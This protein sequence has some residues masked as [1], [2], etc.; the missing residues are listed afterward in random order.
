MCVCVI[1]G[2]IK[3][4]A[5]P[6]PLLTSIPQNVAGSRW[7]DR[8]S[9]SQVLTGKSKA[10]KAAKKAK[11]VAKNVKKAQKKAKVAVKKAH[12][13]KSKKAKAAAKRSGA[14]HVARA[15]FSPCSS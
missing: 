1:S 8:R 10:K 11:T 6:M 13:S 12:K 7:L 4:S 3:L 14:D 15:C 5:C 2:V 9:R